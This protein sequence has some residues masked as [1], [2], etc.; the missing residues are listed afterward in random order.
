MARFARLI[1]MVRRRL[2]QAPHRLTGTLETAGLR[3]SA[4]EEV[5]VGVWR[6]VVDKNAR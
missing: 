3:R 6:F 5:S 4:D 1:W 2:S